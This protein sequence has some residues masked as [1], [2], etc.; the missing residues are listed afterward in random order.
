MYFKLAQREGAARAALMGV[1][2]PVIALAAS[3]LFEGWKATPL[4]LSGM[5]LCLFSVWAA[6]R[7]AR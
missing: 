5:A 2:I 4:A 6:N 7:S 3:A 1:V